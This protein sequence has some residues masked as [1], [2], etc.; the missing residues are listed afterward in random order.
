[1]IA[2]QDPNDAAAYEERLARITIGGAQPR[3]G[4]IEIDEYDP[5][6]PGL[7]A[8]EAERIC[9]LLG[10]RVMRLEHVGSTSVPGLVAKPIIDVVLEVSDSSDEPLYVPD[11]ERGG[12]V[13][14]V[15][16]RDWLRVSDTDRDLYARAKR[17]L[18]A[19]DWRY[20]Q[21]Y[22]DAKT[23]VVTEIL[24]RA[25]AAARRRSGP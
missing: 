7:Y 14:L 2:L 19:Q 21:Q 25:H 15:V 24:T 4:P 8:R 20:T 3:A 6:W 5:G 9:G 13:L 11:L 23:A 22:A 12:Y 16:F 17:E 18:A 10:D 1:M